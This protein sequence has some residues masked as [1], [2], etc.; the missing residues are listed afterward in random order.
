MAYLADV[1]AYAQRRWREQEIGQGSLFSGSARIAPQPDPTLGEWPE[2]ERLMQEKEALGFYL[3][4]NP[5]AEHAAELRSLATHSILE[6]AGGAEGSVTVGG[7]VTTLKRVTIKSG[8]NAGRIMGRFILEDLEGRM[9]V[10]VFA[11]QM[12]RFGHFLEEDAAVLVRGL[13]RDRGAETEL[14][15]EE[16]RSLDGM[17]GDVVTEV[18]LVMARPLETRSALELRD[19]L[20]ERSGTVPVVFRVRL[21]EC[22]VTITSGERYRV[23]PGDE[24]TRSIEE[25]LGPGCVHCHHAP[26]SIT[27]H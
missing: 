17:L 11:D 1:V 12:Q 7:M 10:A 23:E 2:R 21:P 5:L 3:T 8:P 16:I 13:V 14:T 20:T 18:E 25:I 4:G 27:V 6:L 19:L 15:V 26:A 24:L 22:D 9:Q